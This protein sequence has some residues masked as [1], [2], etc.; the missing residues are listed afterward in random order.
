M[1]QRHQA[2][3]VATVAVAGA[4]LGIVGFVGG[5]EGFAQVA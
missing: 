5:D 3:G 1:F 2:L 4:D